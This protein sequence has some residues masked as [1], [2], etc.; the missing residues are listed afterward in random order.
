MHRKVNY[1]NYYKIKA[2]RL[3][4]LLKK[5]LRLIGQRNKMRMKQLLLINKGQ[6]KLLKILAQI[7]KEIKHN[8]WGV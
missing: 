5:I 2:S 6:N 8:Q 4:I 3:Q 7:K 1:E